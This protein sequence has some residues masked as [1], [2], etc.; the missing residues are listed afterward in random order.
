MYSATASFIHNLQ[1]C[2]G[3]THLLIFDYL[4]FCSPELVL[5]EKIMQRVL[6]ERNWKMA[7]MAFPGIIM[8]CREGRWILKL[9]KGEG[10][11]DQK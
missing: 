1:E 4:K 11:D 2:V 9:L 5:G 7:F 8:T 6:V 10:V 3:V